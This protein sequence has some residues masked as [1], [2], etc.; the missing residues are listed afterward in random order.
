MFG[1][2]KETQ[3]LILVSA[4]PSCTQAEKARRRSRRFLFLTNRC[5]R[6]MVGLS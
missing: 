2:L 5:L 6:D 1:K 3:R 4:C